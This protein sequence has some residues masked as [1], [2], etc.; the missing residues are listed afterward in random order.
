VIE[1]RLVLSVL[2][3]TAAKVTAGAVT[4]ADAYQQA[5]AARR[6]AGDM[7]KLIERLTLNRVRRGDER[8]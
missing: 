4:L 8:Q 2:P 6:E 1:A 5:L 3:E 7:G